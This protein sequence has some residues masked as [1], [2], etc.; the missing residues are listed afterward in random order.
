MFYLVLTQNIVASVLLKMR[1]TMKMSFRIMQMQY[2]KPQKRLK[3]NC[4][5]SREFYMGFISCCW[6]IK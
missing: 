2:N 4:F 6:N 3:V 1:R 5:V